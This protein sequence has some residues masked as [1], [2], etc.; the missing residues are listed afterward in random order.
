MKRQYNQTFLTEPTRAKPYKKYSAQALQTLTQLAE[1]NYQKVSRLGSS[2]YL[3]RQPHESTVKPVLLH[4]L[5]GWV[6]KLTINLGQNSEGIIYVYCD[7]V[8]T[9]SQ[10]ARRVESRLK[11]P[12]IF[13]ISNFEFLDVSPDF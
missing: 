1:A 5:Q 8:S 12:K 13:P 10:L 7:V 9:V 2:R 6:R 3:A 11:N 4:H